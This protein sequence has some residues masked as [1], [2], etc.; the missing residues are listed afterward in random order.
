MHKI[1]VPTTKRNEI[2][3][4]TPEI[5]R[6]FEKS[7]KKEGICFAFVPHTSASITINENADPNVEKDILNHLK[8]L[9][10][11]NERFLHVEKNS[12]A[13]VKTS[14]VGNSVHLIAENG[15]IQLGQWQKIMF[16]EFDGP[17]K[18]EVWLK[19]I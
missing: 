13:H 2:I 19:I 6:A 17:R 1:T 8:K 16:L 18:R 10:P 11:E 3:D 15:K 14:L 12:D 7:G 5:Q 9:V 4:I